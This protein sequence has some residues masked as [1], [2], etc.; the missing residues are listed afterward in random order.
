MGN[1]AEV[2]LIIKKNKVEI[3]NHNTVEIHITAAKGKNFMVWKVRIQQR[4][5]VRADSTKSA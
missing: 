4:R 5:L 2:G 3:H 1:A